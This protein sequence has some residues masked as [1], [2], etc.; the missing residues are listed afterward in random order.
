M[1]CQHHIQVVII[2]SPSGGRLSC[3]STMP[4]PTPREPRLYPQSL[5]LATLLGSVRRVSDYSSRHCRELSHRDDNPCQSCNYRSCNMYMAIDDAS[6]NK[7]SYTLH[8]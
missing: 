7:L 1:G 2:S 3:L 4:F 5:A 6:I 8:A